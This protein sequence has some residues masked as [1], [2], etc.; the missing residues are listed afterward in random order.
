MSIFKEAK[1]RHV[2][3]VLVAYAIAGWV[4]VEGADVL[5]PG[6]GIPDSGVR[7]VAWSYVLGFLPIAVMAWVFQWTPEGLKRDF[8]LVGPVAP[9]HSIV[10]LPFVNMSDD[11]YTE[12][13]SDGLAE[14]LLTLLTKIPE[15][16]V[17]SH[18][19]SFAF[20]GQNLQTSEV[21]KRLHVANVLEGS[22]RKAGDK[23]RVSAQ[24]VRAEDNSTL[25]S[26][27]WNRTLD[28]IFVIQEA[29]TRL[30][31]C[32]SRPSQSNRISP[33]HGLI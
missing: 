15:L 7:I 30:S 16:K 28:D 22:V 3:R 26:E 13:F 24:L 18:S 8:G 9:D 32:M 14:E 1:R 23:V 25:W 10:V 6:L 2:F 29:S 33:R 20:K 19:S 21:A 4:I 27:T 31:R 12:Y 17:I 5:F 11:P